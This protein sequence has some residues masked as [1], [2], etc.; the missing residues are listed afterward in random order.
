MGS[1]GKKLRMTAQERSAF[2][3]GLRY[4]QE[5]GVLVLIDGEEAKGKLWEKLFEIREDGGF[6]MGDYV[7]EDVLEDEGEGV[8]WDGSGIDLNGKDMFLNGIREQEHFYPQQN[9]P[10][11]HKIL[12]QIRFDLVYNR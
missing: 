7:L 1:M 3:Q 11:S 10:K 2:V 6:Y 8:F 4:Y 9:Q 5:K 12:K